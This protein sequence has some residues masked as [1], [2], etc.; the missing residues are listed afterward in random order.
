[1]AKRDHEVAPRSQC[2][3]RLN[4]DVDFLGNEV[5]NALATPSAILQNLEV[6]LN[7]CCFG[8]RSI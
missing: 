7:S 6:L 2:N 3:V 1:M 5:A 4:R 8:L